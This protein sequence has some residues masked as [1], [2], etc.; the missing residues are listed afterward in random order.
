MSRLADRMSDLELTKSDD[1]FDCGDTVVEE[2]LAYFVS[3]FNKRGQT[4]RT[5]LNGLFRVECGWRHLGLL[6]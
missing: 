2:A 4:T 3:M 1:S 5:W 6:R